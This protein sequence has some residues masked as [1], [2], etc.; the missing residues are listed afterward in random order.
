MLALSPVSAGI[1]S[2]LT[3]DAGVTALVG[4]RVYDDL[5]ENVTFPCVLFSVGVFS[6]YSGF[7]DSVGS[8]VAQRIRLRISAFTQGLGFKAAQAIVN[9][10]HVALAA[11]Q[12][13]TVTG[14]RV[15]QINVPDTTTPLTDTLVAGQKVQELVSDLYMDVEPA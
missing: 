7:G 10:V 9:A 13:T 3:A 2:T 1:Y 5:P 15:I 8:G 12:G 11:L 14:W 6:N 4:T